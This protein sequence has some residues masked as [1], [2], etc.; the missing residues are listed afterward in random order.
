MCEDQLLTRLPDTAIQTVTVAGRWS[1]DQPH[2]TV[3]LNPASIVA[4]DD[5]DGHDD[6]F[7]LTFLRGF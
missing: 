4:Y 3:M 2:L 6:G 5:G 1:D 7:A